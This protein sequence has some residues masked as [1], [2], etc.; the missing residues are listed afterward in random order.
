MSDEN[1][2]ILN[3]ERKK[4]E[5]LKDCM[6]EMSNQ[7][8]NIKTK[9]TREVYQILSKSNN[10]LALIKDWKMVLDWHVLI[11]KEMTEI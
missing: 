3:N 1:R 2:N 4:I 9:I 6:Q 7:E 8:I 11:K 10:F 5:E